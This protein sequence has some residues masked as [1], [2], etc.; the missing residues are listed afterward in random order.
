MRMLVQRA[1]QASWKSAMSNILHGFATMGHHPGEELLE[2][3]AA[4]AIARISEAT[5]QTV[6]NNVWSFA[7]LQHNPGGVL[8]AACAAQAVKRIREANPQ[9]VANTVWSFA[10]L[11]HNPGAALLQSS[12][13][14]AVRNAAA[15]NPQSVVRHTLRCYLHSGAQLTMNA[16]KQTPCPA[17]SLQG[18]GCRTVGACK[19]D[20]I[21]YNVRH[22]RNN[23][24]SCFA[25]KASGEVS[26]SRQVGG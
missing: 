3:C 24:Q 9:N 2:A 18:R 7:T 15:F 8:L 14:A 17:A 13:A 23:A 4:Q 26:A 25:C 22:L 1:G 6:A 5:P 19:F 12:E 20:L 16:L 21:W 10:T 11:Q